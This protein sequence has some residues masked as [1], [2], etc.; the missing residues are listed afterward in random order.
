[1]PHPNPI[2]KSKAIV[3]VVVAGVLLAAGGIFIY[4]ALHVSPNQ[5]ALYIGWALFLVG[6]VTAVEMRGI[7]RRPE[8]QQGLSFGFLV[9]R[10]LL[11]SAIAGAATLLAY[12][13]GLQ[14]RQIIWVP[15]VVGIAMALFE[16][17]YLPKRVRRP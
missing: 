9:G 5:T 2:G 7:A 11:W 15:L 17:W 4:N 1:M 12:T 6:A 3:L 16:T 10:I 14:D 8:L 13:L